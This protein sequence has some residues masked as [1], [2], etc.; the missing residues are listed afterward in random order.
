M[1]IRC[2]L[3]AVLVVSAISPL[4]ARA[5]GADCNIIAGA[6]LD[7]PHLADPA[8]D[9]NGVATG[10]GEGIFGDVNRESADILAVWFTS[11]NGKVVGHLALGAL[12]DPT[13]GSELEESAY[14]TFRNPRSK[15]KDSGGNQIQ[16]VY[17]YANFNGRGTASFGYG[18]IAPPTTPGTSGTITPA[19]GATGVYHAGSPGILDIT[20][21]NAMGQPQGGD[22]LEAIGAITRIQTGVFLFVQEDTSNADGCIDGVTV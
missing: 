6:S 4:G 22:F 11:E 3:L 21:P 5:D 18:Y 16:D 13:K 2:L 12:N 15:I 20:V 1:K 10:N 7:S 9:W 14:I 8:S 19:G 17:L